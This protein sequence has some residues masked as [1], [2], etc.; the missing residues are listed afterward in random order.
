[1]KGQLKGIV[2]PLPVA[3]S[4]TI[5]VRNTSIEQS[6][7]GGPVTP[8]L[9]VMCVVEISVFQP[10]FQHTFFSTTELMLRQRYAIVLFLTVITHTTGVKKS[11]FIKTYKGRKIIPIT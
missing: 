2:V 1:M 6:V 7:T 10:Y 11:N 8:N 4:G 9:K 3:T 5:W